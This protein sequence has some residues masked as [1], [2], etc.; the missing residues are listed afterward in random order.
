[1][2]LMLHFF[3]TVFSK[4]EVI[5][6]E[7]KDFDYVGLWSIDGYMHGQP[8]V[9]STTSISATLVRESIREELFE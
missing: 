2:L 9:R 1:M 3:V 7:R 8:L 6:N 4:I 5:S